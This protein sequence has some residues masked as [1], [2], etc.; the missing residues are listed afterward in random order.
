MVFMLF[1]LVFFSSR[2][3]HTRCALLTGVQT[4]A[5]PISFSVH[6]IHRERHAS[7][8]YRALR[9]DQM[10][11]AGWRRD[12]DTPAL[13]ILLHAQNVTQ[14][15]D[16]ALH[17]VPADRTSVVEGKGVSVCVEIVER[18]NIKKRTT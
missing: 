12:L 14:A 4:C 5:L 15:I 11:D 2:R 8:G 7:Y 10:G 16:V 1:V 13:A 17:H 3:R 6:L 18:C 9:R